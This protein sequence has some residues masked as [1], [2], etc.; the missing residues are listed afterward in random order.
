M[1]IFSTSLID[2]YGKL[3]LCFAFNPTRTAKCPFCSW[4]LLTSGPPEQCLRCPQHF[5]VSQSPSKEFLKKSKRPYLDSDL[6]VRHRKR[7]SQQ[8][9]QWMDGS[10]GKSTI[11]AFFHGELHHHGLR[12]KNNPESGNSLLAIILRNGIPRHKMKSGYF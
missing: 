10:P 6:F 2:I 7:V 4:S 8:N 11:S 5:C 3:Q 9:I 12:L 1:S